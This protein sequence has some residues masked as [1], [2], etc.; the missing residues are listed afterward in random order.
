MYYSY[1]ISLREVCPPPP[2]PLF[3][4]VTKTTA[5]E[6]APASSRTSDWA[7]R[8]NNLI[9]GEGVGPAA[10]AAAATTMAAA[11]RRRPPPPSSPSSSSSSSFSSALSY[12][13]TREF[14]ILIL[15]FDITELPIRK[16]CPSCGPNHTHRA[17]SADA[18]VYHGDVCSGKHPSI[19]I[20]WL[21]LVHFQGS[22]RGGCRCDAC[23]S[24]TSDRSRSFS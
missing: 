13:T 5:M 17:P 14:G 2:S 21:T 18:Y 1:S 24:N 22:Q 15:E 10:S 19:A 12:G 4:S 8:A 9:N 16:F 7:G 3:A 23:I 6:A 20:A 11:S